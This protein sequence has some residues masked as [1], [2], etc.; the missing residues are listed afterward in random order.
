MN[1]WRRT[2]LWLRLITTVLALS[3]VALTVTGVF[4]ARL[5]RGYLTE[6]VD[7]QLVAQS[8]AIVEFFN[9]GGPEPVVS[10]EYHITRQN[11][12]GEAVD[13][14]ASKLLGSAAPEL[15]AL[16]PAEAIDRGG[17]PFAVEAARGN[18]SWRAV[19]I[20]LADRSG[21]IV[22]ATRLDEVD[23]TVH[24]LSAINLLVGGLV[25][26]GLALA[27][28][29]MVRTALRPLTR[30][31]QTAAAIA[32]GDLSR[33][34]PDDDPRTEVGRLGLALNTMLEQIETAFRA[35]AASE[36][37]ARTSEQKMRRFVADAS[38]ELRTPLTSIRGFAELHRQ[39]AVTDPAEVSRLLGRIEDEAKRMGLLV[40]DLLLL[41]RLDQQRPFQRTPVDLLAV[42]AD[43]V[44][45]ARATAP[46]REIVLD[47]TVLADAGGAGDGGDHGDD[48]GE[49]AGKGVPLVVAGDEPRLRQVVANLL[50]NALSYSPAGTPI[51]MAI[52][53]ATRDG[54][55]L[56]CMEVRD[57]GAGLSA[58]QA[59]RVF[60]RFYRTDKARSRAHGG[61]GLGLS[62]VAAITAAHGGNVEVDTAPGDGATF[63]VLLPLAAPPAEPPDHP[64][65]P[66]PSPSPHAS[67]PG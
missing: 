2:P 13:H 40:N 58:E 4:G 60:E 7:D 38:H 29:S 11:L 17:H 51:T 32:G 39:G 21:T 55:A 65:S 16:T 18:S 66:E 37:T 31:E 48:D 25:L 57:R 36:T 47:T 6:R 12:A 28:Y 1:L 54:H 44:E 59:E 41:A 33:R 46:D 23:A 22:T 64:G 49:G 42:A 26:G 50:D 43:A 27:G 8:S 67:A 15:P 63:R 19:A 5:L 34:V 20:P 62:I 3:A 14:W 45:A 53:T 52:G 61:T 56:A 24:R 30:I 10:G 35:Q 9:E